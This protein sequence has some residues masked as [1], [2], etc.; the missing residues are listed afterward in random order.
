MGK[1]IPTWKELRR[2]FLEDILDDVEVK[3]LKRIEDGDIRAIKYF[4]ET[5]GRARG[6]GQ[7]AENVEYNKALEEAIGQLEDVDEALESD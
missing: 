3:L 5:H 6:Y 4:L 1:K 7:A 2:E